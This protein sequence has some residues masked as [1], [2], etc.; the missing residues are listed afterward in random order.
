M[1]AGRRGSFLQNDMEAYGGPNGHGW[2]NRLR[3]GGNDLVTALGALAFLE[4][5]HAAAAAAR[6]AGTSSRRRSLDDLD[7]EEL[8][9]LVSLIA[10]DIE[11][12][13]AELAVERDV[14]RFVRDLKGIEPGPRNIYRLGHRM[15]PAPTTDSPNFIE[16]VR[17]R[18]SSTPPGGR[19]QATADA[20]QIPN[21]AQ[22][23]G[24]GIQRSAARLVESAGRTRGSLA[25]T[26][27]LASAVDTVR[28]DRRLLVLT[29]VLGAIAALAS[30]PALAQVAGFF[31]RL[32]GVEPPDLGAPPAPSPSS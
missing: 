32:L 17:R 6:D 18:F 27:T 1:I 25:T 3:H 14:R 24:D 23:L 15:P 31:L 5:A 22:V 20:D 11:P 16:R 30:L 19:H 12:V 21:L 29:I 28:L 13:A 10:A 7:P 9:G 26:A 2:S 8:A 4:D